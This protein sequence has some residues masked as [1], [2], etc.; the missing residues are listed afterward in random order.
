MRYDGKISKT[1][2]RSSLLSA[3]WQ[4]CEFFPRSVGIE[5]YLT[6]GMV[7]ADYIRITFRSDFGTQ[8]LEMD[9]KNALILGIEL[10]EM[11]EQLRRVLDAAKAEGK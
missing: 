10:K 11:A 8:H 2:K 9:S 1:R 7:P 6:R 4:P 5:D 3:D